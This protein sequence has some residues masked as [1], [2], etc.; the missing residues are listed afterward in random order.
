MITPVA[1]FEARD[2]ARNIHRAYS[3]ASYGQNL[4]VNWQSQNSEKIVR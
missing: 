2:P 1:Y 4:F 3:V